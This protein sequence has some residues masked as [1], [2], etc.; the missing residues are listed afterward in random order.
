M[1]EHTIPNERAAAIA[2]IRTAMIEKKMTQAE[3]AD[4]A[5][6]HE[7]TV[8]NLIAGRQVSDQTLFDVCAV[9]DLDFDAIKE[10]WSGAAVSGPMELKGEGG[11]VAP[12]YMGAYTKAGV[13]HYI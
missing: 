10:A 4:T 13:A 8:Q 11:L 2:R 9:L 6:C 3:L 12:V 1:P 5:C 7:K